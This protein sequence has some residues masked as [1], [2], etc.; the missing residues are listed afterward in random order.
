[1]V[2]NFDLYGVQ[3]P[4]FAAR[5]VFTCLNGLHAA[6]GCL[7][8]KKL[9]PSRFSSSQNYA[10][11]GEIFWDGENER[12]IGLFLVKHQHVPLHINLVMCMGPAVQFGGETFGR[13]FF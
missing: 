7:K 5:L 6:C 3:P 13:T 9:K 11:F 10:K 12:G 1:M 2:E 4:N 8:K